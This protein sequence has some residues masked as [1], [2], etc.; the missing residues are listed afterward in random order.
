[1]KLFDKIQ[2]TLSVRIK[3]TKGATTL[4]TLGGPNWATPESRFEG[5]A[6]I[7]SQARERAGEGSGEGAR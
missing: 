3:S 4:Q 1:M 5:K 6:R 7:E 2:R